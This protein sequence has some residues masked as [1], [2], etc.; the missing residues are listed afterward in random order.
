MILKAKNETKKQTLSIENFSKVDF[1]PKGFNPLVYIL[2][3]YPNLFIISD[4][5]FKKIYFYAF[6][7][8]HISIIELTQE[9]L[10]GK[11]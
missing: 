8:K 9:I 7:N 5:L 1:S 3:L 4:I 10:K 6:K 11:A 2:N